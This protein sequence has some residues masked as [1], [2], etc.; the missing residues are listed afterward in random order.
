MERPPGMMNMEFNPD[1]VIFKGKKTMKTLY[2]MMSMAL[3]MMVCLSGISALASA[4]ETIELVGTDDGKIVFAAVAEIFN[5]M[6][7]EVEI[8]LPDDIGS[9]SG[10]KAVGRDQALLARVARELRENEA[11]YGLTYVPFASASVAFFAHK[12][13]GVQELSVQ[14]VL[15]IYS[16]KLTNW[17]EVGGNDVKIRVVNHEEGD[18]N[19]EVLED[20]FPGFK[21]ITV[22]SKSKTIYDDDEAIELAEKTKGIISYGNSAEASKFDVV[23]LSIDGSHP[24]DM[25]YPYTTVLGFVFKEQNFTGGLKQFVEFATSDAAHEAILEAG[26]TPL[27]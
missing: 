25:N 17:S 22:L 26:G 1:R 23:V 3:G 5:E 27:K 16:G 7:S 11:P 18:S 15:D 12:D 9:S 6:T 2:V 21:D 4:A 19:R 10:I 14:Q 24:S 8:I 20:A 13:V